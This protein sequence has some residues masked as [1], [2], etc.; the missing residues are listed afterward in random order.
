VVLAEIDLTKLKLEYLKSVLTYKNEGYKDRQKL[1]CITRVRL[2]RVQLKLNTTVRLFCHAAVGLYILVFSPKAGNI[3]FKL[4][5]YFRMANPKFDICISRYQII[6]EEF[7]PQLLCY[8]VSF[9][10][11]P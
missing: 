11:K 8:H 9:L 7:K 4:V 10:S 1:F 5:N 3:T 6:T 2:F